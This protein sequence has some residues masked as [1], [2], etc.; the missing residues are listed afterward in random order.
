MPR[1]AGGNNYRQWLSIKNSG[2]DFNLKKGLFD[3][4]SPSTSKDDTLG[5]LRHG[6]LRVPDVQTKVAKRARNNVPGPIRL[7]SEIELGHLPDKRHTGC[8]IFR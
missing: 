1:P 2:L 8:G 6:H 7:L 5:T 4:R 3:E